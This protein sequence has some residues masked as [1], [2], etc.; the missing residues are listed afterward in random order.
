MLDLRWQLDVKSEF[1]I[2][3]G[4]VSGHRLFTGDSNLELKAVQYVLNAQS[5]AS[6]FIENCWKVRWGVLSSR[7]NPSCAMS[8]FVMLLPL[9]AGSMKCAQTISIAIKRSAEE[10]IFAF[11]IRILC[12]LRSLGN[13]CWDG[14]RA[15]SVS[16][17]AASISWSHS[18]A[19]Q[20]VLSRSRLWVAH[21]CI[22]RGGPRG[23]SCSALLLRPRGSSSS[24][25]QD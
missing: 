21:L 17:H 13:R 10:F 3:S 7:I 20:W 2:L 14:I 1:Q 18:S 15:V 24:G 4:P 5:R 11:T 16:L 8:H 19:G 6:V 9:C 25:Q 12:R 22:H 23:L